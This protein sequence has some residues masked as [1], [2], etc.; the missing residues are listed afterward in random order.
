V[1]PNIKNEKTP[2]SPLLFLDALFILCYSYFQNERPKRPLIQGVQIMNRK[3]KIAVR[4]KLISALE[5]AVSSLYHNA[6]IH[7]PKRS[8]L[9]SDINDYLSDEEQW[10]LASE[11]LSFTLDNINSSNGEGPYIEDYVAKRYGEVYTY[12]RCGA[13]CAPSSWVRTHGG[14][15][16]S[17]FQPETD[18]MSRAQIIEL[19]NDINAWNALVTAE[20][21]SDSVVSILEYP[22]SEAKAEAGEALIGKVS[23]LVT[24]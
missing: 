9:P 7:W 13:T 23:A 1:Y 19:T 21:S 4:S 5:S 17:I 11:T 22:Y 24:I 20:C 8:Q 15:S 14:S 3:R 16:F 18:E 10:N 2:F 12:G 6:S